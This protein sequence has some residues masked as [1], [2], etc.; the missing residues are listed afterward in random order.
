MAK[1]FSKFFSEH[2][3]SV[4]IVILIITLVSVAVV[5]PTAT[6]VLRRIEGRTILGTAKNIELSVRL[7]NIEYLG[8]DSRLIDLNRETGFTLK[9]EEEI[10]ALSGAEGRIYLLS[11]DNANVR[12]LH[13]VYEEKGFAVHI[14]YQGVEGYTWDVYR[15]EKIL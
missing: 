1:K 11:W 8:D 12:I 5:L 15:L 3:K 6:S 10:R 4:Y 2:N 9:A 13:M 14:Q 7:L